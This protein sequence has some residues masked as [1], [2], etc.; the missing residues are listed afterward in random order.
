MFELWYA[1]AVFMLTA[2]VVLDG[3]A[4]LVLAGALSGIEMGLGLSG[5]PHRKGG[6]QAAIDYLAG[7]E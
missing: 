5:V 7:N 1:V 2:Y 3:A 4:A 6:I